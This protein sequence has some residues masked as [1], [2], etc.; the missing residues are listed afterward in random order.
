MTLPTDIPLVRGVDLSAIQGDVSDADWAHLADQE[1]R[2]AYLRCVVGNER[3]TDQNVAAR[4]A[5]R[6]R[7][8]GIRLG[9]YLFAYPLPHLQPAE[10][11]DRFMRVLE[12]VGV[13][14]PPA[15]DLEWP[16]RETKR[17][18]GTL[19]DTW[20]KWGCWPTQLREWGLSALELLRAY[21]GPTPLVYSFPYWLQCIES[22]KAPELARYH[23]WLAARPVNGRWPTRAEAEAVKVPAP[24]DHVAVMQHDGDGGQRLPSGKDADFSVALI[25]PGVLS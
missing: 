7:E 5:K 17:P 9:G 23:L 22:G 20:A 11:I 2:F 19:E 6:A 8:H 21:V 15:I 3:W 18:D 10:Q 25:D 4:N 12:G 1:V 14:L 24:W 13:D 16:P